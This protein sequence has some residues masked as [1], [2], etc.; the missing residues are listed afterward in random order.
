[1]KR[2]NRCA[3]TKPLDEFHRDKGKADG[4][5][6]WCK[7]CQREYDQARKAQK[8]VRQRERY[9]TDPAYR[10]K[11]KQRAYN[12]FHHNPS[13]RAKALEWAR[14]R[15][16]HP[17]YNRRTA[18]LARRRYQAYYGPVDRARRTTDSYRE[19]KREWER[20]RL[21]DPE[22]FARSR[23]SLRQYKHRRRAWAEQRGSFTRQEWLDLCARYN[24]K[25]L[26]CGASEALTADHI[27]PL[28][29]GGS[30]TIDN[31]QPLCWTC[32]N[33]K[34]T[35]TADYRPLKQAGLWGDE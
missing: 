22:K 8:A 34:I 10:E 27:V 3:Q 5:S 13:I 26:A 28:S 29:K 7:V 21:Q 23:H 33:R 15:R 1:M 17:D 16:E 12:N 19:R 24:H 6:Y 32:N 30:N 25:C 4:R 9:A 35:R 11:M 18:E 2:C 20:K 31:I 14:K